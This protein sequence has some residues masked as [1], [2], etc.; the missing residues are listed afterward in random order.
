VISYQKLQRLSSF[1]FNVNQGV[2]QIIL[3]EGDFA[4]HLF[5]VTEGLV[6]LYKLLPDGRQQVTGRGGVFS[7]HFPGIA[8]DDIYA[9]SA[10][11]I[12]PVRLC[13]F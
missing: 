5:N 10:E 13:R 12:T 1:A 11:A 6:K 7:G 4:D 2:R 9:Y 8:M 3:C